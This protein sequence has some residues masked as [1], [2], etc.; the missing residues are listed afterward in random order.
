MDQN[1]ESMILL[2]R[3]WPRVFK[4]SKLYLH[5]YTNISTILSCYIEEWCTIKV[6]NLIDRGS[7]CSTEMS[8][9]DLS[10]GSFPYNKQNLNA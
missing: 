6:S 9:L 1:T 5:Q 8:C 2:L 10:Y 4:I 3:Q 7:Y